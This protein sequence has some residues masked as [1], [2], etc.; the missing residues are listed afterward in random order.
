MVSIIGG[1]SQR[2]LGEVTG[3]D[4]QGIELIGEV[5]QDLGALTGLCVLVGGIM[6]GGIM[7]NVLKML[8]D[9]LANGYL[10]L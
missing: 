3:T 2:Q 4:H 10:H 6:P 8:H 1:P 7:T 9:G 5:H